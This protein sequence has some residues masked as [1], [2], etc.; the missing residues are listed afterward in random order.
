MREGVREPKRQQR[1]GRTEP[2][3]RLFTQL[4]H[5]LWRPFKL[6]TS[7]IKSTPG[8]I[9]L[10]HITFHGFVRGYATGRLVET[11]TGRRLRS[12]RP[13]CRSIVS[14]LVDI[15][16][17]SS[18]LMRPRGPETNFRAR[19]SIS[20]DPHSVADGQKTAAASLLGPPTVS[21]MET[22]GTPMLTSN[23]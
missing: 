9:Y 2:P 19:K 1:G 5:H 10:S 6:W 16:S 21:V 15:K 22:C 20:K 14:C 23:E 8:I 7:V 17:I 18:T 3:E 4:F 13:C 12:E 11:Q